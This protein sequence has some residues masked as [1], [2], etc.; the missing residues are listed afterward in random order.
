MEKNNPRILRNT[1]HGTE[2]ID[3][4][5]HF[6]AERKLF[7]L[8]NV[9]PE[10]ATGLIKQVMYLQSLDRTGEVTLYIDSSGGNVISG[11][12]LFDVLKSLTVPLKTVCIGNAASMAGVLFLAG[13]TRVMLPH[14]RLMLHDPSYSHSNID[15][16]KAHEI[17]EMVTDLDKMGEELVKIISEATSRSIEEIK[18]V[19][20]KDSYFTAQEALE[21]GLAT[22]ITNVIGG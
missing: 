6:M 7:L 19:T 9:T 12:S 3:L 11:L 4:D 15:G 1:V 21:F 10:S 20:R 18:E 16:L 14:S 13:T 8:G 2:F 22:E 17:K 5:E